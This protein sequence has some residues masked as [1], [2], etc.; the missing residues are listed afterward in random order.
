MFFFLVFLAFSNNENY[1]AKPIG[2]SSHTTL[3]HQEKQKDSNITQ[4]FEKKTHSTNA[5]LTNASI[6]I[7]AN[8]SFTNSTRKNPE[9]EDSMIK[10]RRIHNHDHHP[11]HS[12]E[13]FEE[14][15][16]ICVGPNTVPTRDGKCACKYGYIGKEET[17]NTTGCW[18]CEPACHGIAD[19]IGNNTCKCKSPF[20]GDGLTSCEPPT[21]TLIGIT[22][23]KD[24][25]P[26]EPVIFSVEINTNGFEPHQAFCR[27]NDILSAALL[28]SASE[29]RCITPKEASGTVQLSVSFN[30][31]NFS[32]S[33]EYN[34]IHGSIVS[35]S[36]P[37]IENRIHFDPVEG[38]GKK[39]LNFS[40]V[41]FIVFLISII[42]YF[43]KAKSHHPKGESSEPFFPKEKSKK[44]ARMD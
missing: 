20:I 31:K 7:N 3:A 15:L 24:K 11:M 30:G 29:I 6:P 33:L 41:S 35:F 17:M 19:C 9:N 27:F 43:W 44:K 25:N 8:A 12:D 4:L 5:T 39:H 16:P 10:K 1:T 34:V 2:N 38:I 23:N 40:I 18:K 36:K 42:L 14:E 37:Q 32:N 28:A 13:E 26:L 22:P 21:P